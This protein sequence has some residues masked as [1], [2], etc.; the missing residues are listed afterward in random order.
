MRRSC[1]ANA[2]C[3][4]QDAPTSGITAMGDIRTRIRVGADRHI[5]GT[6]PPDVPPGD[7]DIT[8]S[9]VEQAAPKQF[10]LADLPLHEDAWDSSVSLHREDMYGD[11]G[12]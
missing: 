12:R 9:I 6:A 2:V 11:D 4:N 10:R 3:V 1:M 7:H 5:S 8:I